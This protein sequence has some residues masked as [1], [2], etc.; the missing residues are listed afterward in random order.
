MVRTLRPA[1]KPWVIC[2]LGTEEK[3]R[4]IA[5]YANRSDADDALRFI[6]KATRTAGQF[7][8]AFDVVESDE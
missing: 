3:T 7:V 6:G 5:R 8:M 4:I 1:E 2:K